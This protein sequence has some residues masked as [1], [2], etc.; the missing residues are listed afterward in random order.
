MD[1]AH[2]QII[3][4]M[5]SVISTVAIV[6][7]TGFIVHELRQ[8]SQDRYI[9]LVSDL[10][11]VW[12]SREFQEDQLYLLHHMPATNW[13]DFRRESVGNQAETAFN[14]VGGYYD[15]VGGLILRRLIRQEQ[16]LPT[17]AGDAI[18]VRQRIETLVR[19]A[20]SHDNTLLFQ[21]Y[22]A[23]LP[24]YLECVVPSINEPQ[25]QIASVPDP[26]HEA[27]RIEVSEVRKL[28]DAE[29]VTVLDVSKH[30]AADRIPG[31]I[32]ADPSDLEGWLKVLPRGK[33]VVT[34]CT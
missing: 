25:I 11:Q 8:A 6:A 23:V 17:V 31:A 16:I 2:W 9:H 26:P 22:E 5:A 4:A 18:R 28:I 34:Y 29:T 32:S 10:F 1:L 14:R 21:N 7:G 3:S 30:K 24:A 12:H 15:H 13:R 33:D 20:R 27:P 19:E